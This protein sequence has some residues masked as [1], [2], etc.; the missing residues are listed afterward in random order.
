MGMKERPPTISQIN[1]IAKH[2]DQTVQFYRLLGLDIPAPVAQPPGALHASA[3]LENGF[4]FEIDNEY[5]ARIYEE[6]KGRPRYIV[7]ESIEPEQ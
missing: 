1:L 4:A 3:E 2:F 5:L 6:V 7:S